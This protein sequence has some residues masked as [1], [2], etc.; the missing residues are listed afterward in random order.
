M[1]AVKI[2]KFLGEAPKI[3]SELLP[4]AAAQTAFNVK[5]YSGD[6]IPYRLPS[7]AGDVGRVGDIK[8]IYALRD[9]DTG[10]LKWLSWTTDVDIV[11]ATASEDGEQRFYYTGDGAPK[12]SNYALATATGIPYPNNFYELGLPLPTTKVTTTATSFTQKTTTSRARD[13]GNIATIVTSTAHGL[14]TGNIVSI[15]GFP[16]ATNTVATF[17]ATNAEVTVIDST[18]F[19]YFSPGE[20]VST[21]SDS[22]GRVSLAGNTVPRSYVYSWYTPWDEESVASEPSENLYIKEG[23][24]VTV[25]NLPTTKPAGD[26]FI[27]GV[28][29]YRTLASP[30]GTEYFRLA[31]L[32]FPTSLTRVSRASNVSRVTLAFPHNLGVDDRF[33]ISGCTDTTFNITDGTVEDVI[34]AYT[35]EY[36]QTASDVAD[37]AET[38]GTLYHDVAEDLDKPARYWG[39][40]GSYSFTDDFDS[41]N[42]FDILDTDTFDPPPATLK[43]LTSVQNNILCGFDGNQLFFSEPGFPHAWPPEYVLTFEYDIVAISAVGGYILV[44][45]KEYPFQVSGNNPATM[46]FARIDTLYPCVSKRSVVNMGFGVVYA[47]FG[48]LAVYNPSAGADLITKF[49]HDWDTWGIDFDITELVGRF[50]NGKYFGSNGTSSFIFERDERIGGYFVRINYNFDTAW[51]DAQTN[52]FYYIAGN[53]GNLLRWD[54]RTQPLAAME[55]KSKTIVTKDFLN[56]GAA[57]VI[58]DYATPDAESEAIAAFNEGVPAYNL[59]VWNDYNHTS[60]SLSYARTSNVAT[61]VTATAHQLQ[62]GCRVSITGFTSPVGATFNDTEA[63]VTVVNSTTFTY[64]NTGGDVGTTSDGSAAIQCLK[65]LGDLNGPYDRT[66]SLGNRVVN[67]GTLNSTVIN[68]DNLTRSLRTVEGVLPITFR[69]WVN[70]ELVFQGTVSSS[71][72]F[73]LPSGYRSDTFEVGVSGSARVRAIHIGETPFGL[74]TA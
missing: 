23:Q 46:A 28:R 56:L 69:L 34:D 47:T 70:K 61:I 52:D 42:L 65:G 64:A 59:G 53:R 26:N 5:L 8:T 41:R 1:A 49:V 16:A 48:G 11:T 57:R 66:D 33:K 4:D 18:T 37:K 9:P 12:V 25:T 29:L 7:G 2:V 51:Y 38:T 15:T 72:V 40:S 35:F 58:A 55:W 14:R 30:S 17:N 19:T 68:G 22:N 74:R 39:D 13:T 44:L 3:A 31:T 62:T 45:T 20:Q 24:L 10:D 63:I 43:G 71:D 60:V 73:R 21:T 54:L 27:R 6:L 36:N 67:F 32:W 50:Y